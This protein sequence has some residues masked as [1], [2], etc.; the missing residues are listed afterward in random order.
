MRTEASRSNW[1]ILLPWSVGLISAC[2]GASLVFA[3]GFFAVLMPIVLGTIVLYVVA[4]ALSSDESSRRRV[5]KWTFV[6]F[7]LHI[8]I[9]TILVTNQ[10]LVGYI[11]SDSE[12]FH[13]S[14]VSIVQHWNE[15]LPAFFRTETKRGFPYLLASTY[16]VFGIHKIAG[17]V[18]N[19]VLI[20]AAVPILHDTTRRLFGIT[21]GNQALG[22]FVL[23]PSFLVWPS[24]LMREAGVLML[25][26]IVGNCAV[27]LTHHGSIPAL[28]VSAVAIPMVF[29]FRDYI[30]LVTAS[31]FVIAISFGRRDVLP[32]LA[33]G[34]ST[35][36][37][38]AVLVLGLRLGYSGYRATLQTSLLDAQAARQSL[39]VSANS[40]FDIHAN[41]STP[42]AALLYLPRALPQFLLG[43]FPWQLRSARQLPVILDTVA[44]LWIARFT[45]AGIRSGWRYRGRRL[46]VLLV[47]AGALACTLS[48]VM[49]NFGTVVR[50]RP[51][52]TIFLIPLTALGLA[53]NRRRR[54]GEEIVRPDKSRAQAA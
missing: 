13:R 53:E 27:R 29:A 4:G 8:A 14:A 2:L 41:V 37:L 24:P 45:W 43:P 6:C 10:R 49:G 54:A 3:P 30:A 21:V 7:G 44:C 12:T 36:V 5:L 22:I 25:L 26:S 42:G 47:P 23:L 51:Q 18:V 11:A 19:A 9:G 35:L 38:V 31:A 50:E 48:V 1:R 34:V 17:V 32:G 52:A 39:A 40:G 28:L 16:W 15:G 20:S 33:T 46:L